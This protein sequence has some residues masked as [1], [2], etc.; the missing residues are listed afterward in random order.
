MTLGRLVLVGCLSLVGSALVACGN[1]DPDRFGEGRGNVVETPPPS[2]GDG[3]TLT[4]GYWKNH[5]ESWPTSKLTIGGVEYSQAE[6]LDLFETPPRGDT[7]LI[8]GHQ[9]IAALLNVGSGASDAALGGALAEAEAWMADNK[10][11]D[12][13]LPYGIKRGDAAEDAVAL[14]GALADFNEGGIGPGHCDGGPGS[15]SG[16]PGDSSGSGDP[17]GSDDGGHDCPDDGSTGESDGGGGSDP[18]G[19]S[20]PGGGEGGS[21]PTCADPCSDG[22]ADGYIC[23]VGCCAFIAN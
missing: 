3:C 20:D 16:D 6:L 18:G 19:S 12:G 23:V 7:S 2:E 13:R 15:G 4:Q 11:A 14:S 1:G 9:L 17:G 10:D 22:C 8:L 5:E 21:A